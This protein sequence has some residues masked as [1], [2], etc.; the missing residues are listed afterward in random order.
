MK[1]LEHFQCYSTLKAAPMAVIQVTVFTY[2]R[3][4]IHCVKEKNV[5]LT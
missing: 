5:D 4:H 1:Y 3:P 2:L